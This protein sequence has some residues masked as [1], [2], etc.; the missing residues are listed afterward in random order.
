[1][2]KKLILLVD[3]EQEILDLYGTS[4]KRNGFDV[5]TAI[6]GMDAIAAAKHKKPDL[7]LMDLKMPVMDGVEA[8]N[9]IKEDPD[10]KDVKVIF[11]TAF[12][13][14][15]FV[16]IDNKFAEEAGAVDFLKKGMPLDEFI[17]EVKKHLE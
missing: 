15:R 4:L 12:S 17:S 9:K 3:D 1:M 13:D 6:N 7:I 5:V 14:P 2:D 16:G 8:L 10:L 11:L